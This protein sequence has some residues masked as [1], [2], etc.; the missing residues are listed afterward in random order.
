MIASHAVVG[1]VKFVKK[2]AVICSFTGSYVVKVN[3]L[4]F[5]SSDKVTLIIVIIAIC[6]KVTRKKGDIDIL[7]VKFNTRRNMN[8][9]RH[10]ATKQQ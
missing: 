8:L 3:Q 1:L 6:N 4:S 2:E 10:D 9:T 7:L 5:Y